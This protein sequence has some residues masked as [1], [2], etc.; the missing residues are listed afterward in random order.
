MLA[1]VDAS[2]SVPGGEHMSRQINTRSDEANECSR[3]ASY[4]YM[5]SWDATSDA[6]VLT[7][8]L[9]SSYDDVRQCR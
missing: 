6:D 2:K 7:D 9:T 8:L 1:C 4:V 5:R 3:F